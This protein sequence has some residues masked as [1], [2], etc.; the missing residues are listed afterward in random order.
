MMGTVDKALALLDLFVPHESEIGLS[1]IARRSGNDKATARRLLVALS[2][3]GFVEQSTSKAYRLGPAVLRLAQVREAAT[4]IDAIVNPILTALAKETGETAHYSLASGGRLATI[5]FCESARANR[6]LLQPGELLPFHATASGIAYLAFS[7]GV[8]DAILSQPLPRFTD[9]TVVDPAVLRARI[10][11]AR[12][13]GYAI[14]KDGYEDGVFGLAAPILD[15]MGAAIGAIAVAAPGSRANAQAQRAIRE[16]V[17]RA[18]EAVHVGL[19]GDSR[20]K[21]A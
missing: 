17:V 13:D 2:R 16:A 7:H 12:R 8:A 18:A 20:R 15:K 19:G 5:G 11:K 10:A 9:K 6:V 21:A 3:S 4:P 1:D 14:S